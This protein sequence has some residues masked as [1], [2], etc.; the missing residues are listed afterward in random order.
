[1]LEDGSNKVT[2]TR[3]VRTACDVMTG[4]ITHWD[5]KSTFDTVR[6]THAGDMEV[7]VIQVCIVN[8]KDRPCVPFVSE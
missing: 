3:Q 5:V 6:S 4:G 1:M 7:L 8:T 2:L